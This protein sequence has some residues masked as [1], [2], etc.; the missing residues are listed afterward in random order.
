MTTLPATVAIGTPF[1]ASAD[2]DGDGLNELVIT[3]GHPAAYMPNIY[4]GTQTSTLLILSFAGGQPVDVTARFISAQPSII[5]PSGLFVADY[6]GDG[7][8][9]IVVIDT[10]IDFN[11]WP[12]AQQHILLSGPDGRLTNRDVG[13]LT[14]AHASA[15]ADIDRDGDLDLYIGGLRPGGQS[16]YLLVNDGH[17][18]FTVDRDLLPSFV[19]DMPYTPGT[20]ST[21]DGSIFIDANADGHQDLVLLQKFDT[22][23]SVLLLNDGTGSFANSTPIE[24]PPGVYGPGSNAS[25]ASKGTQNWTNAK[26]DLNRDG[27]EDLILSQVYVDT[28]TGLSYAGGRLQILLNNK[29]QG[30]VDASYLLVGDALP[31]A[32]GYNYFEPHVADINGDG[33]TDL[34]VAVALNSGINGSRVFMNDG[35]GR[36]VQDNLF[37]SDSVLLPTDTDLDGKPE[38]VRLDDDIIG[39]TSQG[40]GV[41]S[42]SLTTLNVVYGGAWNDYLVGWFGDDAIKG[43]EGN[44]TLIGGTGADRMDGGIGDDIFYVDNTRDAILEA[45]GQ[46]TDTVYATVSYALTY[47]AAVEVLRTTSATGK[48]S[49]NL[50]GNEYANTIYGNNGTNRLDGKSG[51]D[52]LYGYGGNDIYY[53]DNSGDRVV[54]TSSGGTADVV[55]SSVSHTLTSYVERLYGSGSSAINLTGNS[56]ANIIKGNAGANKI[57]GYTGKDTLYGGS[58]KDIFIFNT[59]P[60]SSNDDKIADYNVTYDTIWLDN[61][62]FTKLGSGSSTSPKKLSS[63]YFWKGSKAHDSN[64]RIIYDGT[65]GYLYYDADG[66]GASKQVLIATL[67]KNLKMTYA[68]FY[69]I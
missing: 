31:F 53:V 39:S 3:R 15:T 65:K 23:A 52:K 66:T 8:K 47:G 22:K 51:A 60:S 18:N 2:L 38:L 48:G 34:V 29:G 44:D 30:F 11:P 37:P 32:N 25:G 58:G 40:L 56:L 54:E 4:D 9:D 19:T 13:P 55:Y 20:A 45:Y 35:T 5:C 12:G 6:N 57:N 1:S 24:L 64:D 36:L 46:G 14:Y 7:R 28:S 21:Y 27:Y 61:K 10:G 26:V 50:Y 68:D 42:P 59:K 43:A 69:V 67:S 16:P 33:W 17:G 49:I 41:F 62:Y 63:S